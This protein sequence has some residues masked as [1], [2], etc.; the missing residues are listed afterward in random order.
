MWTLSRPLSFLLLDFLSPTLPPK[1]LDEPEGWGS[2]LARLN[3]A[4]WEFFRV[5]IKRNHPER[6]TSLVHTHTLQPCPLQW[7][8]SHAGAYC[9][10][11]SPRQRPLCLSTS[12]VQ[13]QS[14]FLV[15]PLLSMLLWLHFP[16]SDRPLPA[17][18]DR[19]KLTLG[20]KEDG[21][22]PGHTPPAPCPPPIDV[23]L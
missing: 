5:L 21:V 3:F 12:Q 15:F 13:A 9:R 11:R 1:A 4:G 8:H 17:E 18:L 23:L 16:R 7:P 22:F 6:M 10:W 14:I 2:L 19:Q 20:G